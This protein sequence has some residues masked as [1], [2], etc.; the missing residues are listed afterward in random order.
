MKLS[1]LQVGV[2]E[3]QDMVSFEGFA[4]SW[5]PAGQTTWTGFE[6]IKLHLSATDV[7]VI[8]AS[9]QPLIRKP[10]GVSVSHPIVTIDKASDLEGTGTSRVLK[11]G[12]V[13]RITFHWANPLTPAGGGVWFQLIIEG[14]SRYLTVLGASKFS[15][16]TQRDRDDPDWAHYDLKLDRKLDDFARKPSVLFV[17]STGNDRLGAL[18]VPDVLP[19]AWLIDLK[20]LRHVPKFRL[21]PFDPIGGEQQLLASLTIEADS[22]DRAPVSSRAFGGSGSVLGRSVLYL[23][24]DL[25]LR[26]ARHV[27]PPRGTVPGAGTWVLDWTEVPAW[28]P[29][30]AAD[31][32]CLPTVYRHLASHYPTGLAAARSR[33]RFTI[34]PTRIAGPVAEQVALRFQVEGDAYGDARTVEL[35][36]VALSP[37]GVSIRVEHDLG[38]A[39]SIEGEVTSLSFVAK[40]AFIYHDEAGHPTHAQRLWSLT[41]ACVAAHPFALHCLSYAL[42]KADGVLA[43]GLR[44]ADWVLGGVRTQSS[45]LEDAVVRLTLEP[46]GEAVT[47]RPLGCDIEITLGEGT[48]GPVGQDPEPGFEFLSA[49]LDRPR[50]ISV[51]LA[52]G[53][54]G[55]VQFFLR[56]TAS[57]DQS[58]MLRITVDRTTT[59]GEFSNDVAVI[60]PAPFTVARVTDVL[61]LQGDKRIAE[62]SDDS[63]APAGWEFRVGR[64]H[65]DIVLPPQAIGEEM[66]KGRLAWPGSAP[67]QEVPFANE[68]FQ[69][70]FSPNAIVAVDRTDIDT[71]RAPP[72]WM[73]RRLMA[74]RSGVTG[75]KIERADFELVYGLTTQV[76]A[77]QLRVAELDALIGRIPFADALV[78]LVRRSRDSA[79]GDLKQTGTSPKARQ[80]RHAKQ[81]AAWLLDLLHRPSWWPLFRSAGER[82]AVKVADDVKVSLRPSR[83]TAHPFRINEYANRQ[84]DP[85][86]QPLRGGVDWLFQ[87]PNIYQELLDKPESKNAQ[88]EGVAFGPLGADGSQ[89]ASYANG[90]TIIIS[91]TKQGHLESL[92]L[93]RIG[94]IARFW[95]HA[96]HVIVY[97]RTSRRAPRYGLGAADFPGDT[98]DQQ[99]PGFE[100]FMAL[101]KVREYVEITQPRRALHDGNPGVPLAGPIGQSTFETTII[102]VKASWAKDIDQGQ[103]INLWGPFEDQ[104]KDFFPRPTI[105]VEAARAGEKGAGLVP[106]EAE[107]PGEY[108]FFTSTRAHDGADTDAW[109][110][111]P[112]VDDTLWRPA[113]AP[114]G[115]FRPAFRASRK[116]PA[117]RGFLLGQA[118][119]TTTVR[120][121]TEAVDL[122]HGRQPNAI[123]ARLHTVSAVRPLP[124]IVPSKSSLAERVGTPLVQADA[125]IS[126]RLAE[127][128]DYAREHASAGH[129]SGS[130][131]HQQFL[132]DAAQLLAD[133]RREVEPLATAFTQNAPTLTR[134]AGA[135]K[136]RNSANTAAYQTNA[137]REFQGLKAVV[138]DAARTLDASS[139]E[140]ARRSAIAMVETAALQAHQ[141]LASVN[142]LP[143]QALSNVRRA[144]VTLEQQI[145]IALKDLSGG[146]ARTVEGV[147]TLYRANP[148]HAE[149][150]ER[151]FHHAVAKALSAV[152][153]IGVGLEGR[154]ATL[155]GELFAAR[156]PAQAAITQIKGMVSTVLEDIRESTRLTLGEIPPF[157][158][159][160]PEWDELS[161]L[162]TG[163]APRADWL[164]GPLAGWLTQLTAALGGVSWDEEI[165]EV[166]AELKEWLAARVA[167]LKAAGANDLRALLEDA[168]STL[169]SA[170]TTWVGKVEVSLRT[171]LADVTQNPL[172]QEVA[173]HLD[174]A[175]AFAADAPA[176]IKELEDALKQGTVDDVIDQLE[177]AGASLGDAFTQAIKHA[178][179]A[180]VEDLKEELRALGRDVLDEARPTAF[181]VTRLLASGVD[182]D[183][184]KCTRDVLGYAYTRGQQ[185]LDV[186]RASAIIN[187]LGTASLNALSAMVPFDRLRDRLLPQLANINLSDLL[188]DLCG[189]KLEHLF[190]E[191]RIVADKLNEYDWLT[192]K[193]GFDKDRLTAWSDMA[194][195]KQFETDAVLLSLPPVTIAL[196]Q[197]R[198]RAHIRVEAGAHHQRV[199]DVYASLKAN[200]KLCLGGKAVVTV[201]DGELKFGNDGRF[202]F[203]FA[204]ENIILAQELQFVTDA[205]KALLPQEEGLTIMPLLPAGISATLSLPLPD[206]G[207]GAFTL[208]G[209]TLNYNLALA[210]A[211]GFEV[212]TGFWLSK[213]DRPFGLAILFLGGGGWAGVEVAYRPPSLFRTR[214]S[215][216]ISAGAFVALNFGFARGSAGLL[217]TAG[218][219]FF[220]ESGG[221]NAGSTAVSLGLL[222]WGEFSI[223]C[224]ASAYLRLTATITYT[225]D[226]GMVARGRV[227]VRI[228]ISFFYTLSVSRGFTRQ[229]SGGSQSPALMAAAATPTPRQVVDYHFLTLDLP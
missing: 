208:T 157:G 152:T 205:L 198:L 209:I 85:T 80:T 122:M 75:V 196:E 77:K 101:R 217:F 177:A 170:G 76:N 203:D 185:V 93:M 104:E 49:W 226:G 179:H 219:E 155:L 14:H 109:P 27:Y 97:Q 207:T 167:E 187:D 135:W 141:R 64:G 6:R 70:R 73:L 18:L 172:W 227:E 102:P 175:K 63:E 186:T 28:M 173:G 47:R 92:V 32:L 19:E 31:A 1:S 82:G 90:K 193:H 33:S 189:L 29:D 161:N 40:D 67:V 213:P 118:R 183:T 151:E 100:G 149:A 159:G 30:E 55:A 53:G 58:R 212:R 131:A 94:R 36:H 163:L 111:W 8:E 147:Q 125:L 24:G 39:Q 224:I 5:G 206:I 194:I 146:V 106:N 78:Q 7:L 119:F 166:H 200:W 51:N 154:V 45:V 44:G 54:T 216:G 144:I 223:L 89:V 22:H 145:T 50:P 98:Y 88:I 114:E 12:R 199:Q 123:E 11:S 201:R 66:I 215:I 9:P 96:R 124:P 164:S 13:L 103:V 225:S 57:A 121:N 160:E 65:M 211:G 38:G 105:F 59:T 72:P 21:V 171:K 218:V 35:R 61:D 113:R 34:V 37:S 99:R 133:L 52:D 139:L 138:Q 83:N 110:P 68:P 3:G 180:I 108:Q 62:Y 71:A 176:L 10:V 20:D 127:L 150:A 153:A 115:A 132:K 181:E 214:V 158:L 197:A 128:R 120:P 140:A 228:R 174:A 81:Q 142:F 165:T 182:T 86:R 2:A 222:I 220:R 116:Q 130:P 162:A 46:R 42:D 79:T 137:V 91:K 15:Y 4:V 229:F 41:K 43:R 112:G 148:A 168:G 210:I 184:L 204:T 69:Y 134:L 126:D 60:D 95:N 178:E 192:V 74:R 48:I 17:S 191:L 221:R 16:A 202:D 56:E 84:P 23:L 169:A 190:P 156:G 195:D 25:H 129:P 107:H 143:E 136:D 26:C 188:P 117:A 87:S